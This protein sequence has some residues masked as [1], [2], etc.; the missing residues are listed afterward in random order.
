MDK[1]VPIDGSPRMTSYDLLQWQT[2]ATAIELMQ[3]AGISNA[4]IV[5]FL[6][7]ANLLTLW[8]PDYFVE[9]VTPEA[10]PEYLTT[11]VE[12]YAQMD[13]YNYLSQLQA[14]MEH[15]VYA[16]HA[17]DEQ[18]Y[19]KKVEAA[20]LVMGVASDHMVNPAPGKA[21]SASIAAPYSNINSNCGHMGT[22]CEAAEVSERVN[23]FLK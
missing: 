14:M 7:L 19:E 8:T 9:N 1:A 22:T 3:E 21:L 4:K 11:A 17:G 6:S 13:A 2:H 18:S 5:E 23:A 10:L 12:A 20:V 15:D 16:D